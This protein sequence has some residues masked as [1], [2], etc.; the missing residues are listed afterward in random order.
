MSPSL[1]K[2][3]ISFTHYSIHLRMLDMD[4]R[5][6]T[7]VQSEKEEPCRMGDSWLQDFLKVQS[8]EKNQGSH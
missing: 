8:R 3:L 5:P 6:P 2:A 4:S 7:R 1:G